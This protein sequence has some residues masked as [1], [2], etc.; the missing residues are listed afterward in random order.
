[1]ERVIDVTVDDPAHM[2]EDK[3]SCSPSA[4]Q[5]LGN[6][7]NFGWFL[8]TLYIYATTTAN[9]IERNTCLLSLTVSK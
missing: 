7:N 4:M 8:E 2:P 3:H 6:L 5:E 9:A 1:M